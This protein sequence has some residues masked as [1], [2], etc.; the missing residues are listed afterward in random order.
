MA[1]FPLACNVQGD[2]GY[3]VIVVDDGD[4]IATVVEKATAPIV[5]VLVA[6]FPPGTRLAA[7]V[8]GAGAP[9]PVDTRVAASGLIPM[10]A[11]EIYAE[12]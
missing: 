10:E 4:T 11:L 3:K 5:G 9:L 12:G 7:R 2:Y 6:P 8:K 1:D